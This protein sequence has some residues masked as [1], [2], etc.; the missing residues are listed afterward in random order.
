MK[1]NITAS[2]LAATAVFTALAGNYKVTVTLPEDF[3]DTTAL[4]VNFDSGEKV[5]SV[6]VEQNKAVFQGTIAEPF[7]ARLIADGM[8][9]TQFIL[10]DGDIVIETEPVS[11]KGGVLNE[12]NNA[13]ENAI[14]ELSAKVKEAQT[15]EEQEAVYGQYEALLENTLK[16][17]I[18]NPIGYMV[19]MDKAYDMSPAEFEDFLAQNPYFTKFERVKNLR[20]LNNSKLST[21]EGRMFTDFEIEYE[22]VKHKLSD[23]VGKGAPV[24]VDFWASW[25]GPCIRQTVVLKD[26][27]NEYKDSGL[28]VL[29]VAVWDEPENTLKAIEQHDLPWECWL[30][31]QNVPTDAYGISGIPCII[32]FG[33]DGTILSRD[34]QSDELKAAVAEFMSGY[35][36]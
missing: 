33:P 7:V 26:I 4:I 21:S 32:L 16:E 11:V 23:V 31:G 12:K 13:L 6:V 25:C 22:G 20:V 10:E 15:E 30:N 34:K 17:N 14:A 36:K 8:R 19:F 27:Y 24:L 35:K 5:D 3:E 18:D 28:K 9:V 2:V 29:G 1:K